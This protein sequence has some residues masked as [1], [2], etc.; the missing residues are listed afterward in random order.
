MK[1]I[2]QEL[3]NGEFLE[4]TNSNEDLIRVWFQKITNNFCLELNCKVI[5]ATKTF[6]PIKDKLE[7][8][9]AI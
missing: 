4:F 3:L 1:N 2:K 5:K 9:E 6:K 8:L 7:F